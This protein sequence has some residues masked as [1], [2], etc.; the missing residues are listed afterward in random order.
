MFEQG[1]E[2]IQQLK[3]QNERIKSGNMTVVDNKYLDG[4]QLTTRKR[5]VGK[6]QTAKAISLLQRL[7]EGTFGIWCPHSQWLT[8]V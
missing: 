6:D 5:P 8:E 2:I 1:A 4:M 7:V 3:H